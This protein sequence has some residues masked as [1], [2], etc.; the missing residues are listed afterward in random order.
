MKNGECLSLWQAGCA[1]KLL[2]LLRKEPAH[3]EGPPTLHGSQGLNQVVRLI[4]QVLRPTTPS[5]QLPNY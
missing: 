4:W 1:F 3:D 2:L 5:G